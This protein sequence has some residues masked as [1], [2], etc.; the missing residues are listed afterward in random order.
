MR[1]LFAALAIAIATHHFAPPITPND[2]SGQALADADGIAGAALEL[3][4]AEL[5]HAHDV[6][7]ADRA[8][9]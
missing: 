2:A 1:Y 8:A 5:Q 7:F 6:I 4:A 3:R 9:E